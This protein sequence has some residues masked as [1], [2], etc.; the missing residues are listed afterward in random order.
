MGILMPHISECKIENYKKLDT[1]ILK[2]IGRINLITGDNNIGKTTL[3][4]SLLVNDNLLY[5]I[6]FI[7]R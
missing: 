3:L 6:N 2:D 5:S 7:R 1:F 4:E